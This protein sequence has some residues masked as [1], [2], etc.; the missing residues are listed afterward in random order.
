MAQVD[1]IQIGSTTYD[2]LQSDN[3]SFTGVSNDTE[4][5]SALSWT[6]V[7]KLANTETNASIFTK[8]SS[9][10]K[11]IR[12]LYSKIGD[13][14]IGDIG[15]SIGDAIKNLAEG[16][17]DKDHTHDSSTLKASDGTNLI[18]NTQI[19]DNNHVP[20]SLLVKNMNDT[21]TELY[22]SA[23]TNIT[24]S[25]NSITYKNKSGAVIGTFTTQDTTYATVNT[26]SAGL[27]PKLNN[28]AEYY[29]NGTGN[30]T[31]PVGTTYAQNTSGVKATYS[32]GTLT[33]NSLTVRV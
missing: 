9:M 14:D 24:S 18:S 3:A 12:F 8:M 7:V 1:Q 32:N 27:M 2:I 11:N 6:S 16:K 26:G 5:S 30:W 10:F 4:D 31:V 23:I 13:L 21:L 22:D 33:L 19:S 20:S 17:A 29:M 25:G 28:N 15:T